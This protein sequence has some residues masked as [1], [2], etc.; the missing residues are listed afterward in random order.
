MIFREANINDI[1]QIQRVR[2]SVKENS[3]S[4]R[5]LVSDEDVKDFISNRGK[6]WVCE[7]ENDIVGFAIA[8]LKENNIWALFVQPEFEKKGIGRKLHTIMPDWYFNQR[9]QNVWLGT[10]PN[11]R[12]AT[13]YKMLGWKEVGTHGKGEL[14]FEMSFAN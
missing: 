13:F 8:D 1:K 10:A 9:G 4:D 12:A 6:D 7:F 11:T 2:H 3:L 14:K 5:A